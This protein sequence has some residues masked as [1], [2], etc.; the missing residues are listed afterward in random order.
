MAN[1]NQNKISKRIA[2]ADVVAGISVALIAIPQALAYAELAGMPAHTGLY[3][4]AFATLAAAFFASSPYIQ[5][6][7]VATTSLLTFGV[8]SQIAS[9]SYVAAAGLLAIIVGI[10]R[11]AIGLLK[12][13]QIAYLLSQPVITGFISAAGILITASQIPTALGVTI[14]GSI[15]HKTLYSLVA[16]QE[17]Q[18]GALILTIT[19]IAIVQLG[20]RIHPLFPSVLLAVVFGLLISKYFHY[21]GATIGEIPVLKP[22]VNLDFPFHYLKKLLIGGVIIAIVGFSEAAS[23]ARTY[24]TLERKHWNPNQEFIAQG[25]ANI[26]SGLFGGFPVGASFSRSSVNYNAGAKTRWSGFITGLAVLAML[27]FVGI[28]ASLPKAV[29]AAIIIASVISLV[30]ISDLI[31]LYKYSKHQGS[32]AWITFFLTLALAPE[33]ELAVLAGISLSIL[34]HLRREST[35]MYKSWQDG[36]GL[37]IE[38][39]GVMWFGSAAIM[40]EEFLRIIAQNP[41]VNCIHFHLE[42][43][44]RI[45]LSAAMTLEQIIKDAEKSGIKCQLHDVP[46]MAKAWVDRVWGRK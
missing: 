28:F 27:P 10:V 9:P 46:P 17:W 12:F 43:I 18:L 26:A 33:I 1:D 39:H 13:G 36:N 29:L 2:V 41:E 34:Q 19:T 32:I 6:G 16:V 30:R 38:P 45:D 3:A 7:P 4:V 23:I 14:D 37:H 42:G 11:I 15:L 21:T 24:A 31:Q 35:L 22:T 5:A 8:L 44:G 40:E 25:A 20:K